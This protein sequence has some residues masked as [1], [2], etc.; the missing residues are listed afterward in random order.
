MSIRSGSKVAS[1]NEK[2]TR[3][4]MKMRRFRIKEPR[5][6]RAMAD[7]L[8]AQLQLRLE[9]LLGHATLHAVKRHC[10]NNSKDR[11]FHNRQAV[12]VGGGRTMEPHTTNS[13]LKLYH[14]LSTNF[15]PVQLEQ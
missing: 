8:R 4:V 11:E 14:L 15:D 12:R 5:L 1:A 10:R 2:L 6:L 9:I 3:V 13:K 7:G